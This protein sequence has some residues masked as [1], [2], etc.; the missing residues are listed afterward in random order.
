MSS[1]FQSLLGPLNQPFVLRH[2]FNFFGPGGG[3]EITSLNARDYEKWPNTTVKTVKEL[4]KKDVGVLSR[5]DAHS[6]M[7]LPIT[8]ACTC[9]AR[10]KVIDYILDEMKRGG[11][12]LTVESL[13]D[14]N[15]WRWRR[16]TVEDIKQ[17]ALQPGNSYSELDRFG[18]LPISYAVK[19]GAARKV[20]AFLHENNKLG[21]TWQ[22]KSD[23]FTLLHVATSNG[24]RH[25]INYLVQNYPESTKMKNKRNQT[26]LDIANEEGNKDI[27]YLLPR[28]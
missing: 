28:V 12:R 13:H 8:W 20:V 25:L 18:E 14:Q 27:V 24:H 17:A 2:M 15:G 5:V 9:N 22:R 11:V 16:T 10:V 23:G 3:S 7:H 19:Y 21:I 6:G 26:P 4:A 1:A